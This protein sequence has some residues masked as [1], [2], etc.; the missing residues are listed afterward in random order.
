MRFGLYINEPAE[1][2]QPAAVYFYSDLEVAR[3]AAGI[4]PDDPHDVYAVDVSALRLEKDSKIANGWYTD[5]DI[6]ADQLRLL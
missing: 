2:G 4:D 3:S 5:R 1:A 6:P